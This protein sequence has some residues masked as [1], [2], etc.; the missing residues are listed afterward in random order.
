MEPATDKSGGECLDV[1]RRP[2]ISSPVEQEDRHRK[3][4]DSSAE[5]WLLDAGLP[6][7]ADL[8]IDLIARGMLFKRGQVI[9]PTN[10]KY[11]CLTA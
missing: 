11:I 3:V 4:V 1:V 10:V 5:S 7:G 6:I 2:R 8:S 9:Y